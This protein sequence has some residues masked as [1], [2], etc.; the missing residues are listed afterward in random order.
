MPL[1][2]PTKGFAK[3]LIGS[4]KNGTKR[5]RMALKSRESS[6]ESSG[7][8]ISSSGAPSGGG[9]NAILNLGD[10]GVEDRE[11]SNILRS[12]EEE[13]DTRKL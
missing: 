4:A 8:G 13:T 6:R 5:L 3:R 1:S 12:I 2:T 9:A 10:V 7:G 11:N